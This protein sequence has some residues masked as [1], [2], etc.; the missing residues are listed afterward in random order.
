MAVNPDPQ[1]LANFVSTDWD[2]PLTM[3]NLL[4]FADPADYGDGTTVWVDMLGYG[5]Q[6]IY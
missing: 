5:I 6:V 1:D 4:K 2:G 3:V